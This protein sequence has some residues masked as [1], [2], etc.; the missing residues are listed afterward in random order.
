MCCETVSHGYNAVQTIAPMCFL[1][2]HASYTN[3]FGVE[4]DCIRTSY[5]V[6]ANVTD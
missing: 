2:E 4:E 3:P 6:I 5:N 1:C